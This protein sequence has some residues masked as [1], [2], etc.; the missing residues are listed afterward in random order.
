VHSNL[1]KEI[2]II[3]DKKTEINNTKQYNT[4]QYNTIQYNTIQQNKLNYKK[5]CEKNNRLT[6]LQ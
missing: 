1:E 6:N 4:I 5:Y 3:D 2:V